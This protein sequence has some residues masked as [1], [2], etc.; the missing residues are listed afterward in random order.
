MNKLFLINER[1]LNAFQV[2]SA[3]DL[4]HEFSE[5]LKCYN[6]K[7]TEHNWEARERSITQIRGFL[8]GNAPEAY[9][10]VLVHGIRNMVDGI[11]KAVS[12]FI[13]TSHTQLY[14]PVSFIG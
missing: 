8:R 10:D 14:S 12:L 9:L 13:F 1:I 11:I 5:M 4:E 7:E 6:D 3:K 2:H